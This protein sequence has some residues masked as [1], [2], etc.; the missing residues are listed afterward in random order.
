MLICVYVYAFKK[1][2]EEHNIEFIHV[3][4]LYSQW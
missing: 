1:S 4:K 3:F 2:I